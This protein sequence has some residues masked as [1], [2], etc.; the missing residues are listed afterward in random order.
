MLDWP[1]KTKTLTGFFVAGT[2]ASGLLDGGQGLVS[3]WFA[4]VAVARPIAVAASRQQ[5]VLFRVCFIVC[6]SLVVP[7]S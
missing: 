4:A 6:L 1:A 3:G 2:F 5:T 7:V